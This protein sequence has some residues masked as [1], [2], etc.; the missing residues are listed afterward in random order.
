MV[1]DVAID[2]RQMLIIS[3]LPALVAWLSLLTP[4]P[5]ALAIMLAGFIAL[6]SYDQRVASAQQFPGWYLP[7]RIRL[8]FIVA[9]CLAAAIIAL[10]TGANPYQASMS[11]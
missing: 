11:Q 3:V 8:T 6:L 7:L 2:R 1:V 5:V 10:T 9:L 4:Y